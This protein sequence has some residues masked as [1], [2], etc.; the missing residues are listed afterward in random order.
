MSHDRDILSNLVTMYRNEQR[1][2]EPDDV[3]VQIIDN[4]ECACTYAKPR[5]DVLQ[6]FSIFCPVCV[7]G[8]QCLIVVF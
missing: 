7:P 8:Y 3:S 6:C 2:S 4:L 5:C 1:L